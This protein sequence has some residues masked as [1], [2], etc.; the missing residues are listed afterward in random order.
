M[1][2]GLPQYE[3]W[4]PSLIDEYMRQGGNACTSGVVVNAS[5]LSGHW[6]IRCHVHF[7]SSLSRGLSHQYFLPVWP[8]SVHIVG[9]MVQL[10][11]LKYFHLTCKVKISKFK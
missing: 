3:R 7:F 4:E 10:S 11:S 5:N 2:D 6:I 9:T 8:K 1:G